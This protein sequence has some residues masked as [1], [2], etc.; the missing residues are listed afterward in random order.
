MFGGE[1][2]IAR[3]LVGALLAVG[4]VVV[5]G[6]LFLGFEWRDKALTVRNTTDARVGVLR[7]RSVDSR[8]PGAD[9]TVIEPGATATI[10]FARGNAFVVSPLVDGEFGY[11]EFVPDQSVFFTPATDSGVVVERDPDDEAAYRLTLPS[12][13][14][15]EGR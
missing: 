12:E 13:E 2:R 3:R 9:R 14:E 1:H 4:L 11:L 6:A 7:Y 8:R 5:L 10:S 15:S